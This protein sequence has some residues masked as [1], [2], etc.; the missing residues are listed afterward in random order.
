MFS[1]ICADAKAMASRDP[2]A[3][4]VLEV[5]LLYP[6]FHAVL[7]YRISHCLYRC[8]LLF[9]ARL[10][11][12]IGRFFTGVEIHPG[13]KIGKGLFIDH[14]MGIV[15]GETA[16]IGENCTIYHGVTLGG[17][18]KHTGKR[19]PTIGSNVLLSAGCKVLGPVVVGDNARIGAN[20]VVLADV[21][22]DTTVV[23]V[24][25]KAVKRKGERV[26]PSVELD[27]VRIPD[28]VSQELCR[29]IMRLEKME[30]KMDIEQDS[31][32][33]PKERLNCRP[34]EEDKGKEDKNT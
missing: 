7:F 16:E 21:E 14:G 17:T 31:S 11:S 6:G 27:Q 19:H 33:D 4:S 23:G 22:P 9:L 30:K 8:R 25:G 18:G 29:I 24:P 3:R 32:F 12:N 15:I 13:A 34:N 2:A 5:V 1:D 10:T 28:P 26:A 20:A